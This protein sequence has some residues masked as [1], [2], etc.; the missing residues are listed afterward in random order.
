MALLHFQHFK[1]KS[2]DPFIHFVHEA[3]GDVGTPYLEFQTSH[4]SSAS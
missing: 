4:S 3:V 1:S 2:A